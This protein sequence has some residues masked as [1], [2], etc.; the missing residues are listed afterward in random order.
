MCPKAALRT[1]VT[2]QPIPGRT[3]SHLTFEMTP[4]GAPAIADAKVSLAM[5]AHT[6]LFSFVF[7]SLRVPSPARLTSTTTLVCGLSLALSLTCTMRDCV[8]GEQMLQCNSSISYTMMQSLMEALHTV[9]S[10][11][12]VSE[13]DSEGVTGTGGSRQEQC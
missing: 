12:S 6:M 11:T 3:E 1:A 2:T 4:Q 10:T 7:C 13:E 5:Q 9:L 8:I